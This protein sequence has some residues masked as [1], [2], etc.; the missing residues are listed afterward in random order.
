MHNE[1]FMKG[2]IREVAAEVNS[3]GVLNRLLA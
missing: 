2:L 3:D 1:T